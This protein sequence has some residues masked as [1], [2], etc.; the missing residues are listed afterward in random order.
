MLG[1]DVYVYDPH[2]LLITSVD[3]PVVCEVIK[4]SRSS[5][6]SVFSKLDRQE[7]SRL[8]ADNLSLPRVQQSGRGMA[9]GQVT[10][11]LITAFQ[12]LIDLLAEP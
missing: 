10:L 2:H 9:I 5:R 6:I 7:M 4:A 8:I 1:D 11:P 3:L 12:R